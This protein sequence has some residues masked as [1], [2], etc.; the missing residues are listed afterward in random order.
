MAGKH[1]GYIIAIQILTTHDT[2][3]MTI[4]LALDNDFAL[5]VNADAEVGLRNTI[6]AYSALQYFTLSYEA[7]P[8]CVT[9]LFL[10]TVSL[11]QMF[12]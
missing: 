1:T 3:H 10:I 8:H 2:T 12:P 4:S 9:W 6:S 5:Y 7:A 11:L